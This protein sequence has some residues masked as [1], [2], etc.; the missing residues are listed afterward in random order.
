MR[1]GAAGHAPRGRPHR[2]RRHRRGHRL[3]GGGD[4]PGA[5]GREHRD[6][7]RP[8]R[9]AAWDI[10]MPNQF[11]AAERI[12]QRRGLSRA[13][14]DQFGLRS[15]E[16]AQFAWAQGR[17][18]REVAPVKAPVVEAGPADRADP[19]GGPGRGL[20]GDE[21]GGAGPAPA[22]AAGGH[23]HRGHVLADL[24][25]GR[26]D[27]AGGGGP[28]R[29]TGPAAARADRRPVPRRRRALLPPGRAHRGHRAG[30]RAQRHGHR[31]HRPVRDQRGLR[32]GGACRG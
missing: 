1:L 22:G 28:G 4:E 13:E 2:G 29:G 3:R 27:P 6:R 19:R 21:P 17:F 8:P 18:E 10:D 20:A 16:K 15:Q 14:L 31:R 23:A 5:A 7:P 32:L 9:P 12:A 25:R 26:R 30:A 11:L 24:R